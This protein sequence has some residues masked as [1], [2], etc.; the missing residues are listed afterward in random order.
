MTTGPQDPAASRDRLRAGHADREQVI[1][2]LK[3]AFVDGRLT[4]NELAARTGRAL[5][6]RTYAHL[7][8]LTADIPAEAAAAVPLPA[9]PTPDESAAALPAP[10]RP[11]APEIRRPLAKA[12]AISGACLVFAAA[13]VE[14]GAHI[15]PNVPGPNPHHAWVAACFSLA[16]GAVILAAFTVFLGMA[17]AIEQRRSRRHLPPRSGPG[18]PRTASGLTAPP[19]TRFPPAR[20]TDQTRA[21]MR[22]RKSRPTRRRILPAQGRSWIVP[23]HAA[24][25]R[26]LAVPGKL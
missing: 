8:A 12:A 13:A 23:P 20:R 2:A 19:M 18:G 15:D 5:A 6:A 25:A 14:I 11:P 21:D 16:L 26:W 3:T 10:T 4:K 9:E 24:T 1:E 7:A 17:V 22:D